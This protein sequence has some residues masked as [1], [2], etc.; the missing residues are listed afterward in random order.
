MECG[1]P[2]EKG[3]HMIRST[4]RRWRAAALLSAAVL[5]GTTACASSTGGS[6]TGSTAGGGGLTDVP[7]AITG[8]NAL[9]LWMIVARDQKLMEPA[10]I[11]MNLVIFS[12]QAQVVPSLLSGASR[13]AS[14]TP[15]QAMEAHLQEK[16]LNL[17]VGTETGSP[18]SLIASPDITSI[19]DLRGKK[20]GVNG[21]GASADYFAGKL[22]LADKGL[23]EGADYTFTNVGVTAQRVAA[24]QANQ[25]SA[26]LL[27]PPDTAKALDGGA[28]QIALAT[29]SPALKS[30]MTGGLVSLSSWYDKNKDV[31]TKFVKGYQDTMKWLY[32]PANR[33]QA[34]KDFAAQFKI[35]DAAA[36]DV[37]DYFITNVHK[38][39]DLTGMVHQESLAQTLKNAQ[40]VGL[41]SLSSVQS[42]D[43]SSFYD[44]AL[45]DAAKSGS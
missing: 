41:K 39:E 10:G 32:D 16:D 35:S 6:G 44:N 30:G 33:A 24:L 28:K 18:Y 45:V 17:V 40:T 4:H 31:A 7:L 13:F 38:D 5:M 2:N 37:Y 11:K 20:I 12:G 1:E 34:V 29:D 14:S 19:K 27:F 42:T 23:Q 9:H 3:M 22:L 15:E 26:V 36:G 43:L 21:V 8:L 25:V